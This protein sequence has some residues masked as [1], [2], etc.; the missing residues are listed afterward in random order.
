[1]KTVAFF[2]TLMQLASELAFAERSGDEE[3]IRKARKAHDDYKAVCL[4]AD[5]VVIGHWGDL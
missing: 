5:E 1:M 2:N 3:K 4:N